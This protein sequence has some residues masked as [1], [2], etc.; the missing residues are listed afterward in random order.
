MLSELKSS[1]NASNNASP[2]R[3]QLCVRPG[4]RWSTN[5]ARAM[6]TR[7]GTARRANGQRAL[8]AAIAAVITAGP[9]DAGRADRGEQQQPGRARGHPL[10][11]ARR[12]RSR[13][14]QP[15]RS[16]SDSEADIMVQAR[17]DFA[18]RTRLLMQ[19]WSSGQPERAP[20]W[21]IALG[22][23]D[24][25]ALEVR[26][27]R[28]ADQRACT[29]GGART[30]DSDDNA[31]AS[32]KPNVSISIAETAGAESGQRPEE[33]IAKPRP[34]GDIHAAEHLMG[35]SKAATARPEEPTP[36]CPRAVVSATRRPA[37]ENSTS[38]SPI[39]TRHRKARL[40]RS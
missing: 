1:S 13:T 3:L 22:N 35:R 7:R 4:A 38:E 18:C 33:D 26:R 19:H 2:F 27:R 11:S 36:V 40:T 31:E 9:A 20:P 39:V 12:R 24:V 21:K 10:Q 37:S 16:E 14:P 25:R 8:D 6:E 34:R 29:R 28:A 23:A 30:S 15:S 17:R 32:E 5:G